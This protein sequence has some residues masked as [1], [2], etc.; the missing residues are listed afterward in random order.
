MWKES[1]AREG[2]SSS[3]RRVLVGRR[4]YRRDER[5]KRMRADSPDMVG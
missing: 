4:F 2:G 5:A 3:M 1:S